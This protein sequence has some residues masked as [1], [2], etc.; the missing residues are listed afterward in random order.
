MSFH[1][2]KIVLRRR[3]K[4]K[5]KATLLL[6]SNKSCSRRFIA[7]GL[8]VLVL[9]LLS[10]T[11]LRPLMRSLSIN[12]SPPNPNEST[13]PPFHISSHVDTVFLDGEPFSA[14]LRTLHRYNAVT[15]SPY[16]DSP[17][18]EG[19]TERRIFPQHD[20]DNKCVPM[21]DWQSTFYPTCN[22]FHAL[23]ASRA[24][25]DRDL[26]MI[27]DK[28]YWRYAWEV[29]E[30]KMKQWTDKS[31]EKYAHDSSIVLRTFKYVPRFYRSVSCFRNLTYHTQKG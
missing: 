3:P 18:F 22:D 17:D 11:T 31:W 20:N 2:H 29:V 25:V 7:V 27:S 10:I 1:F 24:L 16:T 26:W 23:D 15:K 12:W 13:F 9:P 30:N 19:I 5:M 14:K 8:V 28:G 21:S 4:T 6:L